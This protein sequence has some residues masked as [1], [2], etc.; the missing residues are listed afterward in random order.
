MHTFPKIDGSGED[1][2][3]FCFDDRELQISLIAIPM[4]RGTVQWKHATV[5]H[6]VSHLG[7]IMSNWLRS[8][9]NFSVLQSFAIFCSGQIAAP[10]LLL[11]TET[12]MYSSVDCRLLSIAS[13]HVSHTV[14]SN[15][16]DACNWSCHH[17]YRTEKLLKC[18]L[19]DNRECRIG[20]IRSEI[21]LQIDHLC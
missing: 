21:F 16:Q 2:M 5:L 20:F 13:L 11:T 7:D 4:W 19:V 10:Q 1:K 6:A 8:Q 3:S 9:L 14:T 12:N 15:S 17:A 18:H